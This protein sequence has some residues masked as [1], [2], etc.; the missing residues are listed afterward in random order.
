VLVFGALDDTQRS[1]FH[2]RD[3]HDSCA[4]LPLQQCL[5]DVFPESDSEMTPA[6]IYRKAIRRTFAALYS[7]SPEAVDIVW[8]DDGES[9]TV[10]CSG[11]TFTHQTNSDNNE[12]VSDHE[13][14]VT[15]TLTEDERYQLERGS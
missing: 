6:D 1:I 12:F 11:E 3:L 10:R 5:C 8:A 14:P 4:P 7:I 15:V 2:R 9:I 13:D